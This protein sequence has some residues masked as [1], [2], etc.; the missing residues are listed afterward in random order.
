MMRDAS[1]A[2]LDIFVFITVVLLILDILF[3][4][5]FVIFGAHLFKPIIISGK[6]K[7]KFL[8]KHIGTVVCH[9]FQS[10]I[11]LQFVGQTYCG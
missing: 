10:E 8:L 3:L 4:L 1:C 2:T 9:L 11:A 5:V 7:V 6:Q